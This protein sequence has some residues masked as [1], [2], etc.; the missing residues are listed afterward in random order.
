MLSYPNCKA[1]HIVK[2]HSTGKQNYKCRQFVEQPQK[3]YISQETWAQINNTFKTASELFS[4]KNFIFLQE[5]RKS[6]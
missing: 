5:V 2:N 1:T 4:E 3:K 6:H